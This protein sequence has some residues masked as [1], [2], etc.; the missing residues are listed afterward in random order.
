MTAVVHLVRAAN[1][2]EPFEAFLRSYA[3]HDAGAEHDLVLLLKGFADRAAAEPF[4]RRAA[5]LQAQTL[6][7]RDDGLDLTAYRAAAET[8]EHRLLCF[9]NSFST[10]LAPGWLA[11]LRGAHAPA[12]VGV[13]GATGSWGSHR[14]FALHLL[15]LPNGY[16]GTLG[17]RRTAGPAFHA[18]GT[19]PEAGRLRRLAR[20]AVDLPREIAGHPGFP[21]AH[22]RTNAFLIERELLRS[23]NAGAL[24]S[25]AAAYR[26]EGGTRGLPGQLQAR[27]LRPVIVGRTGEAVDVAHWPD[28]D[29]FWQGHQGQLLVADNQ[30][31]AYADGGAEAR[32]A[33]SRYA[34]GP[35]ARPA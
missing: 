13:V 15:R 12:D 14:S 10:V 24:R 8:L 4:V 2:M 22:V 17:D 26:F 35:R 33:L 29:I 3:A 11:H 30:T 20:A 7:V 23:L 1:G 27:G 28:V 34:W 9:L 21:A 31:R 6:H 16:R 18:V 25:K 32:A 19:A 5:G